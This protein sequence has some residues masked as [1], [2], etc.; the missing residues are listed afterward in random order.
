M[1]QTQDEAH[2]TLEH[3]ATDMKRFHN[4]HA[5]DRHEYHPRDLVLLEATNIRTDRLSRKLD[6]KC[7][8]PFKV[9]AKIG[10]AAYKLKLNRSWKCYAG[11]II[12]DS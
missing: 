8:G 6:N 4:R 10:A 3:A 5:H 1:K 2:V 11:C 12:K 7:Y 9:L